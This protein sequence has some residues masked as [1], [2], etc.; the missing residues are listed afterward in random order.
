MEAPR[1]GQAG[2]QI[3]KTVGFSGASC[4]IRMFLLM[5]WWLNQGRNRNK[6][7]S[8]RWTKYIQYQ[9]SLKSISK[10]PDG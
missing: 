1:S 5:C 9:I 6:V 2:F 7:K 8:I 10:L 4:I 3:L